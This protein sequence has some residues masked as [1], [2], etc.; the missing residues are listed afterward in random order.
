MAN[1]SGMSREEV[2]EIEAEVR[3][4]AQGQAKKFRCN[5]G[6]GDSIVFMGHSPDCAWIMAMDNLW[7]RTWDEVVS[8]RHAREEA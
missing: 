4:R 2:R 7:E 8:E 1:T 6:A 3:K 5:C